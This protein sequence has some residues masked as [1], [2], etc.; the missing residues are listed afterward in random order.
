MCNEVLPLGFVIEGKGEIDAVPL[1]TRRIC[2]ELFGFYHFRTTP[3]VRIPKSKLVQKGEVERAVRLCSYQTGRRGPILVVLDADD[4]CP[5][6][7]GTGL[8]DGALSLGLPNRVNVVLPKYEF[9]TWFLAAAQSLSGRRG[10]GQGLK[11]PPNVEA[12]R[13]AKEWLSRKMIGSRT[14]SPSVDQAAL[15]GAMDLDAARSSASFDRFCRVIAES[16]GLQ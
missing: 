16:C 1:L 4:D 9:E 6:K 8:R 12:I 5:A 10:L 13:G 15:V 7:L 14:Y 3:P 11:R 2:T